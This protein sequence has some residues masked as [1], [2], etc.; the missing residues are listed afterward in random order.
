M[1][2]RRL[3]DVTLAFQSVYGWGSEKDESKHEKSTYL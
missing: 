1:G 2:V 3:C